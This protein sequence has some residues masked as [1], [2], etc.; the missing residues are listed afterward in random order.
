MLSGGFKSWYKLQGFKK[1]FSTGYFGKQATEFESVMLLT[2]KSTGSKSSLLRKL[3]DWLPCSDNVQTQKIR[4]WHPSKWNLA[5][6][7]MFLYRRSVRNKHLSSSCAVGV[8]LNPFLPNESLKS[9]PVALSAIYMVTS[10][11]RLYFSMTAPAVSE[12]SHGYGAPPGPSHWC[13][14]PPQSHW[15]DKLGIK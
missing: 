4:F 5:A 8:A 14:S 13:Y 9:K 15:T 3:H 1:G 10:V 2:F 12:D 7:L 11:R 6:V